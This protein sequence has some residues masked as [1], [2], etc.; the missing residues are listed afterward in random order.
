MAGCWAHNKSEAVRNSTVAIATT[1]FRAETL[2]RI[3]ISNLSPVYL[4]R[5]A[6]SLLKRGLTEE[7]SPR[8]SVHHRGIVQ[9]Y[10][11]GALTH[12]GLGRAYDLEGDSSK[13][14]ATGV[15]QE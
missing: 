1:Y 15:A 12:L 13:A 11:L 14:R 8:S 10:P 3:N 7:R 9:N 6:N 5:Q 4:Q 2:T